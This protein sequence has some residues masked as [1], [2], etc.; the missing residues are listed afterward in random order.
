MAVECATFTS[1][2]TVVCLL[3]V[4]V[5]SNHTHV[6]MSW[7]GIVSCNSWGRVVHT[8]ADL[9]QC[10]LFKVG[11]IVLLSVNL[12]KFLLSRLFQ[13]SSH[14]VIMCGKEVVP[15]CCDKQLAV[16][17]RVLYHDLAELTVLCII[18]IIILKWTPLLRSRSR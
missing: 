8:L 4:G 7:S 6:F 14:F 17:T 16:V 10:V 13:L 11:L 3:N 1:L 5:I 18:F 12:I 2:V 15:S 9:G